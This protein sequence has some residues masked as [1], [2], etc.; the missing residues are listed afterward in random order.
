MAATTLQCIGEPT[1]PPRFPLICPA[2]EMKSPVPAAG[3]RMSYAWERSIP[4]V[5]SNLSALPAAGRS[6]RS[7]TALTRRQLRPKQGRL[8][9][10]TSPK[11]ADAS[12][13][14]KSVFA[15]GRLVRITTEGDQRE[16]PPKSAL[17]NPD[18]KPIIV[19]DTNVGGFV[20]G[21]HHIGS[22]LRHL[23]C[24]S[25]AKYRDQATSP[26]ENDRVGRRRNVTRPSA[27]RLHLR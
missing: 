13:V 11:W 22:G 27:T 3:P 21:G 16:R 18:D 12:K 10:S 17:R 14:R 6:A 20:Q 24:L 25:T 1:R 15:M 23:Q 19:D 9:S 26:A 4:A 2:T 7:T 8:S 5:R